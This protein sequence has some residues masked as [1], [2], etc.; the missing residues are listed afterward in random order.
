MTI[1]NLLDVFGTPAQQAVWLAT[2]A[3]SAIGLA[4]GDRSVR[5][6]V[7]LVL[8]NFIL[9]DMV[10]PWVWLSIRVGV[11]TLDGLLFALLVVV[12]VRSRRWWAHAAAAFA[13][14]G[15]LAHFIA[16]ADPSIWW[17]AY[18]L[19]RWCFSAALVLTLLAGVVETP[20]ARTY[21]RWA[22]QSR[23]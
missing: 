11:A 13:L 21:E 17:H 3:I 18:V 22:S 8:S 2:L 6:G 12:A 15:F 9:S 7:G 19:L 1:E 4:A 14:L 20:L 5:Y 10:D 16:L 23:W